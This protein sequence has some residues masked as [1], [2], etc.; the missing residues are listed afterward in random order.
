M[1]S[2]QRLLPVCLFAALAATAGAQHAQVSAVAVHPT[3]AS[4]VWACNRDNGTV[5]V[6]DATLGALVAEIPVGVNPRSIAF[7]PDGTRAYVANQRG[8][9]PV[10]VSFISPFT[11]AEIRGTLSVIDTATRTVI[12][13]LD[14]AQVGVEPYGVAVA[15]SGKYFAVTGFR[16][17]TLRLFSVASSGQVAGLQFLS[18]LAEIPPPFTIADADSNR[19]QIADLGDP[20]GFTIRSDSARIYVTHNK[21][22]FISVIDVALDPSGM[23]IGLSIAAKIDTNEYPFDPFFTPTPVQ[24]IASQG[25][26]RFLEDIALA[27]DGKRALIPHLLHNVN[28]DVNFDFGPSLPGN[29]ANRVYPALT[30]IDTVANTF[31]QAGDLSN[32][33]HNELADPLAPAEYVPFGRC[34]TTTVGLATL[35]GTGSPV[36]GGTLTFLV[37]GMPPG[38]T[39]QVWVGKEKTIP[40]GSAGTLYV[41][42]RFAYPVVNGVASVPIPNNPG[43]NGTELSAQAVIFHGPNIAHLSNGLRVV[44]GTQGYGQNKLGYRAGHPSRVLYNSAGDRAVLLNRGSEDVFLYRVS[45]SHMELMGVFPPRHGFTE[46]AALDTTTPMGDLPLGA[47]LVADPSTSNDDAF[48]YVVNELTRSLSVLRIDFTNGVILK[49][50]NQIPIH[51]G[52]DVFSTSARLGNELFEDASRPQTS[53]N[54]NNSCGSCHFEGGEDSNVWQRGDGPR[55]T[56]PVYGGSIATGLLLWRGVRLNMGETG[57]MFGGENGGTGVFSDAEQQGLVDFHATV[58]VPLNPNLDPST[59]A[60]TPEA[61]FGKDLFFATNDTGL[62]PT[63]RHAGCA[64][65][66]ATTDSISGGV[67]GFTTDFLDPILTGGENLAWFDPTCFSLQGNIVEPNVRNVNSGCDV[68]FDGDGFPDP[69]RNFDGYVDI[70]T[71]AIMNT[72]KKSDFTRDDTNSY[73]CPSDPQDPNSP[74]K[75]FLRDMRKFSVPTKLGVFGTGPYFHDHS[76]YSLRMVVDPEAQALSAVY[77]DPAF[78]TQPPYPGL[79]KFFNEFHDVRG[80]EQ[81]APG[82]SKVQINLHSPNVQVDI[83]AILAFIQ[84]I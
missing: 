37:D 81:Y 19:D 29:F 59:G 41:R 33:L 46:R 9:V 20:R 3:N 26:P 32:R 53:G 76:A 13:T 69:D 55:T 8:N 75:V 56:M 42:M 18:N 39:A 54:F 36:L 62:N 5:A 61:A 15:P 67:R 10:D 2:I 34:A 74:L 82:A 63:L 77:G 66:H 60:L 11:G 21:S 68:D 45:G 4:E 71:Y 48:L 17:G 65:C 25:V 23:P 52:P 50:K 40:L 28:H 57:P 80:H 51:A 84:S 47:A 83:E 43:L 14:S 44:L 73:P 35:G 58:P 64:A 79:N 78:P 70:E 22:P 49:H 31:H 1:R 7:T 30:M 38:D 6:V 24:V 27:P 12:Q 16:S 72:D